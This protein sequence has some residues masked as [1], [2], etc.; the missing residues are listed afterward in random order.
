MDVPG[1]GREQVLAP[2]D[3]GDGHVDVVE[4]RREVVGGDAVGPQDDEVGQGVVV[5]DDRAPD[6]VLDH[7]LAL[8]GEPEADRR[9]A[10]LGLVGPHLVGAQVA[11]VA[12]VAGREA[13]GLGRL[14]ALLQLLGG[15]VAEVGVALRDQGVDRGVVAV[16]ALGLHVRPVGAA[17]EVALVPVEAEPA[18]PVDDPGGA[19]GDVAPGV[20]VLDAEHELAAVAAREKV[21]VK[22]G[23]RSADMQE[24]GRRRGKPGPNALAHAPNATRVRLEAVLRGK[25]GAPQLHPAPPLAPPY[26]QR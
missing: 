26:P 8:V 9:L 19:V 24:A 7:R 11:A 4:H 16:Q 10:P 14:A 17:L 12:V 20:G 15:A 25:V 1:R 5:E 3:V 21:R 6:Q 22:G 18:Q 23:P 13:G 2:D